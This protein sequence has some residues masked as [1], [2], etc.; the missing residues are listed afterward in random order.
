MFFIVVDRRRRGGRRDREADRGDDD[1]DSL[2]RDR[3]RSPYSRPTAVSTITVRRFDASDAHSVEL[4]PPPPPKARGAAAKPKK[5]T[6][7]AKFVFDVVPSTKS[8]DHIGYKCRLC[9][10]VL[11]VSVKL[12]VCKLP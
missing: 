12:C 1:D 6:S 11:N 2:S 5:V 10:V 3:S 8:Q 9:G 4:G 7:P